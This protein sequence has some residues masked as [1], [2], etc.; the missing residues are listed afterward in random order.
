M[1]EGVN[2]CSLYVYTV[3]VTTLASY[4]T[5]NQQ[6]HP[7]SMLRPKT[8][9]KHLFHLLHVQNT[10]IC[11]AIKS[12]RWLVEDQCSSGE[13]FSSPHS[14]LLE[15]E[16]PAVTQ[17]GLDWLRA[18]HCLVH[19]GADWHCLSGSNGAWRHMPCHT[20]LGICWG[21]QHLQHRENPHCMWVCVWV[22][23]VCVCVCGCQSW[24]ICVWVYVGSFRGWVYV[25]GVVC[26]CLCSH[27]LVSANG[28]TGLSMNDPNPILKSLLSSIIRSTGHM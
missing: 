11:N 10:Y 4:D 6:P 28:A 7:L 22:C 15:V 21:S 1:P 8:W 2:I 16:H 24:A 3:D 27:L 12:K 17:D 9:G 19:S 20:G 18:G 23:E 13:T 25:G 5:V 14:W 26:T